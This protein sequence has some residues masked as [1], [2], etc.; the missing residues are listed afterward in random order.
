MEQS[1]RPEGGAGAPSSPLWLR[2]CVAMCNSY[3]H[4]KGSKLSAGVV[5]SCIYIVEKGK[6]DCYIA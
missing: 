5:Y 3:K 6:T 1:L 4:M 2:H